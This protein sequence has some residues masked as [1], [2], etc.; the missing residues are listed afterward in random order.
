M[1]KIGTNHWLMTSG[2]TCSESH[3]QL[4]PEDSFPDRV[5]VSA[6]GIVPDQI[7]IYVNSDD[8]PDIS[9]DVGRVISATDDR[10]LIEMYYMN[11]LNEWHSHGS[12]YQRWI[13]RDDV[14]LCVTL[15]RTGRVPAAVLRRLRLS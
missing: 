3:L 11:D 2:R 14:A 10:I 13:T 1:D 5:S 12:E 7:L 4:I 15:T 6:N 8:L 9:Y